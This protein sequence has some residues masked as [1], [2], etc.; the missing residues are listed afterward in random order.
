MRLLSDCLQ[1]SR[2]LASPSY[3]PISNTVIHRHIVIACDMYNVRVCLGSRSA[4]KKNALGPEPEALSAG[5]MSSLR[6]IEILDTSGASFK[7]GRLF[8][9]IGEEMPL[10]TPLATPSRVTQVEVHLPTASSDADDGEEGGE[11][12]IRLMPPVAGLL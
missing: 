10:A 7:P 8:A 11:E 12:T 2:S 9:D 6:D 4:I 1:L 3:C 5:E